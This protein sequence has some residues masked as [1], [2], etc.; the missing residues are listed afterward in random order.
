MP[1]G[2]DIIRLNGDLSLATGPTLPTVLSVPPIAEL[3]AASVQVPGYEILEELGRGG[4]G[5][6][7]KARQT[8]LNRLV[9][10]KVLIGG[11]HAG[12]IEKARFQLEAEAVARLQHPNI[13]QVFHFGTQADIDY[14]AFEYVEGPT[15]RRYQ[16]SK[17]IEPRAAARI[18]MEIARAVQHAHDKGIVHRDLKPSNILLARAGEGAHAQ[19]PYSPDLLLHSIPKVMDFGLAKPISGGTDL[20]LTGV[21]CGTPNYMAPEQVRGGPN[22]SRPEVDIW[23]VG[24]VLFEMLTGRPPFTGSDAASIMREILL[25]DPP[26]VTRL[27]ARIPRDLAT[28]VGKCLE[29]DTS[30]RYLTPADAADDLERFLCGKPIVA[31]PVGPVRHVS[32]WLRRN[33]LATAFG[34]VLITTLFVL[35]GFATALSRSVDRE[36]LARQQEAEL[37]IAA[38]QATLAADSARWET[39][40]ALRKA[41]DALRAAEAEKANARTARAKAE[42]ERKRAEENLFL[43]RRAITKVLETIAL[44]NEW[45]NAVLVPVYQHLLGTFE[46]VV[47]ELVRQSPEDR[48]IRFDQAFIKRALGALNANAGKLSD[49]RMH[50]LQARELFEKLLDEDPGNV[51]YHRELGQSL[52]GAASVSTQLHAPDAADLLDEARVCLTRLLQSHPED[53]MA[54]EGMVAVRLL[55]SE[56]KNV[57]GAEDH[58]HEVYDLLERLRRLGRPARDL[59][60][61]R[62]HALNNLASDLTNRGKTDEAEMF[63]RDVL[64]LREELTRNHPDDKIMQ[65]ELGK[66]LTNYANQ[67]WQTNRF[68]EAV[69]LRERAAAIFD[70]LRHDALFRAMYVELIVLNDM[71][72]AQEYRKAGKTG[73]SKRRYT[74]VIDF[75]RQ[76]L[77]N[78][79]RV[80]FVR[81]YHSDAHTRRAELH[82]ASQ[83]F[84]EAARDYRTASEFSTRQRHGDY[85]AIR[86]VQSLVRA[87]E[88]K[89]A[90]ELARMQRPDN[91]EVPFLCVELARAWLWI[92]REARNSS[93]MPAESRAKHSEEAIQR[94]RNAILIGREKGMASDSRLLMVLR[95]QQ[96]LEPVWDLLV[97]D[98]R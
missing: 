74:I 78:D 11:R 42:E 6:V 75:T 90:I 56:E 88:L 19:P 76:L 40:A 1:D 34:C 71:F 86:A 60:L 2:T 61:Y 20:T 15:V 8:S 72:I 50:F 16:Q 49:A 87:A 57:V 41:E 54:L 39:Q 24:A 21:A 89:D 94:A 52:L 62:A 26:R 67:L 70:A 29:K 68:S 3:L 46:P 53:L 35:A 28:I 9:A 58:F 73:E 31:R 96:D 12:M 17:P 47:N 25:S 92:A 63:W 59:S 44:H 10:L 51:R 4:M 98:R 13:V 65:Y 45:E 18:A 83:R 77:K 66:C 55:K 79:P 38:Q 69:A 14:I 32:R 43:A 37:R 30:C 5:V 91:Y 23:G 48:D 27:A 80:P 93:A 33:P 97:P 84:A 85:C 36:R 64:Q 81:S 7:Y 22:G 95:S 82:E